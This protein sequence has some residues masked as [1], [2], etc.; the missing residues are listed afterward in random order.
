[1]RSPRGRFRCTGTEI[2]DAE[3][4]GAVSMQRVAEQL[5]KTKM[6]L[7]R[8]LP[9]KAELIA[10][11][12]ETALDD[13]PE[14]GE[15]DWRARLTAWSYGLVEMLR[16]HPWLLEATVGPR[17]MGPKELGWMERAL[18]ALD[19]TG[20]TGAERMDAVVL[21]TSHVRGI[22]L[23]S[24]A[25][26]PSSAPEAQLLA[27]LGTVLRDHG[28]DYPHLAAATASSV[29]SG[30]QGQDQALEF[31]LDRILD[32]LEVLIAEHAWR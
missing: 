12:V 18:S 32:G 28:A 25:A 21:L 3:G 9:G 5:G 24:R 10:V 6:S 16:R 14:G 8:Y 13:A 30:T 19:G 11:M 17:L 31:G 15:D 29:G 2:A 20:L 1:M 4:L 27:A 22:A 7:Y 26:A 23:Q